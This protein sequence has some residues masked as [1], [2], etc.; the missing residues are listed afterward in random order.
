MLILVTAKL[1]DEELS[2]A[3]EDLDGYIK[4]VV[5]VRRRI[6]A[7]GGKRHA[8]GEALLLENGSRQEDLWGAGLDLKTGDVDFDSVINI[9]P[10]QSNPSREVLNA[11]IRAETESIIRDLLR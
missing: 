10:R 1:N 8:D 6:L 4:V 9:R 3:A 5:D 2:Q 7:A 11:D